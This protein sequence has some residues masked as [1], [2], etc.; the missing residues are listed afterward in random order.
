M[1]QSGTIPFEFHSEAA[2]STSS[3]AVITGEVAGLGADGTPDIFDADAGPLSGTTAEVE[4]PGDGGS[5]INPGSI[6]HPGLCGR[7]CHFF[8]S[9][10]CGLQTTC[11]FCHL[12]HPPRRQGFLS[13]AQRLTL[14]NMTFAEA[15]SVL[16][17]FMYE[18]ASLV[19]VPQE[20]LQPLLELMP[21]VQR[22]YVGLALSEHFRAMGLR[23]MLTFL[24]RCA[25]RGSPEE[26]VVEAVTSSLFP[27][28]SQGTWSFV[29]L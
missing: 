18:E 21:D 28:R 29:M 23:R 25:E 19:G 15:V 7:P 13:K 20:L 11:G 24:K 9:G 8:L 2:S 10:F 3:I 6:G 14:K 17:P 27:Q 22:K 1:K 4:S 26:Q 16:Y 5:H 12:D